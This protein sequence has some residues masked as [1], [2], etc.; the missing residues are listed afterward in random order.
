[1]ATGRSVRLFLAEGIPT[2]ILTA[3]IVNWTGHVLAAPR[4]KIETALRRE[5]LSRTGVY[6]LLGQSVESTLPSVYIGEGDDISKRLY[7]HS[8]DEGKEFWDRF[9][10]V[11]SKDM[12]L[13]KA[14]VK[15][16]EGRL[17]SIL[18]D[19]KK[20]V[21]VN[22]TEPTFDRLPEADISDM[23]AFLLEIQLILPVVG[24][25]VFRKA[26]DAKKQQISGKSQKT[27]I[28][29]LQ[30]QSK[31]INAEAAEVDGEFVMQTGSIGDLYEAS[32]F[33]PK[34][35][36][37]REQLIESGRVEVL[38]GKKLRLTEN[39]AFTS[40]SAAAVFLFGTS[41]N[42]RFDWKLKGSGKSYGDYKDS[43]INQN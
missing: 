27:V 34:I 30:H 17:I 41:R 28:F 39:V 2:G 31:G 22:R 38:G 13:T 1:M 25:D 20:S 21:L 8:K 23:E 3:E 26:S 10:A 33:S 12:N 24:I 32:S 40:P 37:L 7:A 19:A 35:K 15:F 16:L 43:L 5:E 36:E 6:V 11:T 9:V 14:H 42:G 29:I 18:S 4:T